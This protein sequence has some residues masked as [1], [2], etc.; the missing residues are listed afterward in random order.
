MRKAKFQI[1]VS[2]REQEY[3]VLRAPNGKI[4]LLSEEYKSRR[5]LLNGIES[6]V[7]NVTRDGAFLKFQGKGGRYRFSL[8]AA[9]NKVIG[10]SEAYNSK[11][12]RWVGIKSVIKNAP[13]AYDLFLNEGIEVMNATGNS[14][15]YWVPPANK[16]ENKQ[17]I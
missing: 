16:N 6:V 17:L 8:R 3:F 5:S 14:R 11:L 12:G 4:I 15:A 2:V 7:R 10:V 13:K 1:R 9:N